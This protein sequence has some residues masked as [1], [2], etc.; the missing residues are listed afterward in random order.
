MAQKFPKS[1]AAIL[2]YCLIGVSAILASVC[3]SLFY[4]GIYEKDFI[5][6]MGIVAFRIMYHL[7]MR[8]IMGN[9]SKVFYKHSHQRHNRP[10]VLNIINKKKKYSPTVSVG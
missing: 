8:I 2:M 3:L 1:G 7:W 6:W 9:V 4:C 5:L 10:R